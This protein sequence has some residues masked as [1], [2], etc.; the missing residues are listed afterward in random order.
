MKQDREADIDEDSD[1]SDAE[2]CASVS[3][4]EEFISEYGEVR[5]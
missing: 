2:S 1:A 4:L 5:G 3:S